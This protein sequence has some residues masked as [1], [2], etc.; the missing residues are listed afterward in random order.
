MRTTHNSKIRK[1]RK[2]RRLAFKWKVTDAW[3]MEAIKFEECL[4]R[5]WKVIVISCTYYIHFQVTNH[6]RDECH[7]NKTTNIH[8]QS[9]PEL[10]PSQCFDR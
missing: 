8:F 9:Q 10:Q 2:D 6:L 7:S 4:R 1:K 3:R 5:N